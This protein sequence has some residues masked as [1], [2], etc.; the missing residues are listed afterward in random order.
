MGANQAEKPGPHRNKIRLN[1]AA[2]SDNQDSHSP[3]LLSGPSR[4]SVTLP[5]IPAGPS[6]RR[7]SRPVRPRSPHFRQTQ[8]R[9]PHIPAGSATIPAFSPGSAT[10][11]RIPAV[12]YARILCP[13][14]A[15]GIYIPCPAPISRPEKNFRRVCAMRGAG[16]WSGRF[17][18]IGRGRG[19]APPVEPQ[20]CQ[21][22]A[23][24]IVHR[25]M[26]RLTK[27]DQIPATI[28]VL[29]EILHR[30]SVMRHRG[31][32]SPAVSCAV[33]AGTAP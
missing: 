14:P 22:P 5:R 3:L 19:P 18:G 11:P 1:A 15:R 26:A 28:S 4:R 7:A 25:I 30:P 24:P 13:R 6:R 8:P 20:R 17:R 16:L 33:L 2:F 27:P 32:C 23:D 31:R 21:F 10:L 29:R 12:R 9:R